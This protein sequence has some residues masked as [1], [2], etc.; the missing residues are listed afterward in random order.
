MAPGGVIVIEP[1]VLLSSLTVCK[2][3][4]PGKANRWCDGRGHIDRTLMARGW[5]SVSAVFQL[6]F[7]N[8]S[9]RH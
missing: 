6:A 5:A 3:R 4:F 9:R 7:I 8:Y 1:L 2:G